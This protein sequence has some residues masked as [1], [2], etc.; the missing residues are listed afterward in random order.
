MSRVDIENENRWL[1][2]LIDFYK[3]KSNEIKKNEPDWIL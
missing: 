2:E 1:I 3:K